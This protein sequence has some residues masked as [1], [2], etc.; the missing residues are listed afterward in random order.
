MKA[1]IYI[2]LHSSLLL[3]QSLSCFMC[4]E[5]CFLT[6]N[7]LWNRHGMIFR[8]EAVLISSFLKEKERNISG[9]SVETIL[10]ICSISKYLLSRFKTWK[11]ISVIFY[12]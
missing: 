7:Q 3:W 1:E 10:L 11:A 12:I 9:K 2:A 5:N 8:L 4:G 6:L